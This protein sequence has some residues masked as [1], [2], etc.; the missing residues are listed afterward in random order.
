LKFKRSGW[1]PD[2]VRKSRNSVDISPLYRRR[3]LS[4]FSS[5]K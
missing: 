1:S 2:A 3:S 5:S 4:C